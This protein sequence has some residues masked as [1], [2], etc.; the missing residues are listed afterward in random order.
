MALRY[1]F[2]NTWFVWTVRLKVNGQLDSANLRQLPFNCKG[3]IGIADI[4]WVNHHRG[5]IMQNINDGGCRGRRD[6]RGHFREWK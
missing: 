1:H 3:N 2:G 4:Q 6:M 5:E